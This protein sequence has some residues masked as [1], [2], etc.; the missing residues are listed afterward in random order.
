M[1]FST[2]GSSERSTYRFDG[3]SKRHPLLRP[4]S[5]GGVLAKQHDRWAMVG[6]RYMTLAAA[7][8]EWEPDLGLSEQVLLSA[9]S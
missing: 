5:W 1:S 3:R 9:A 4:R 2:S 6:R 7:L 8:P